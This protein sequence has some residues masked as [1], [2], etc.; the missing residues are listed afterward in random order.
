MLG[1]KHTWHNIRKEES[2]KINVFWQI[3]AKTLKNKELWQKK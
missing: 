1:L 3:K 2:S